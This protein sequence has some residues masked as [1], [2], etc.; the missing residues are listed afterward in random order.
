MNDTAPDV[1]A[2]LRERYAAMAPEERFLIGIRMFDSARAFVEASIP[3]ES[4]DLQ[5]RRAICRRF[6][7][8]LAEEVFPEQRS[9]KPIVTE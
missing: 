8:A 7:P 3:A 2:Y 4:T 9:A 6:Y 1:A 5:R